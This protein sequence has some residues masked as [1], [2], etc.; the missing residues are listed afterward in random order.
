MVERA[1]LAVNPPTL[2]TRS[3][4]LEVGKAHSQAQIP[5]TSS[6]HFLSA[7]R[8]MQENFIGSAIALPHCCDETRA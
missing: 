4:T 8:Q 1:M 6:P 7:Y 5:P 2:L 3:N